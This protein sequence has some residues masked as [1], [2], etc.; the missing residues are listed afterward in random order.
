MNTIDNKINCLKMMGYIVTI[1]NDNIIVALEEF[2]IVKPIE[3]LEKDFIIE[4]IV[5][6]IN[7]MIIAESK[8]KNSKFY[9]IINNTD[10]GDE[11]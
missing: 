11:K 2:W 4:E 1:F 8:I 7:E 3:D 5:K 6:K 10:Y 9:K